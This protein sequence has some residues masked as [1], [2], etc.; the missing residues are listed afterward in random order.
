MILL[1]SISRSERD[2]LILPHLKC[3]WTDKI[4]PEAILIELK[5]KTSRLH[6]LDGRT[7]QYVL[8]TKHR[9][10]GP[11]ELI[12]ASAEDV[13]TGSRSRPSPG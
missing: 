4:N 3:K 11:P 7:I 10:P 8:F 13:V 12:I 6:W 1:P 5:E 2:L 9:H